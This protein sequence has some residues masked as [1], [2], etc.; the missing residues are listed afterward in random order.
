V[1]L[2]RLEKDG[3]TIMISGKEHDICDVRHSFRK[4]AFL[5]TSLSFC[6]LF[7]LFT[8]NRIC[9]SFTFSK[10]L[11]IKKEPFVVCFYPCFASL[12]AFYTSCRIKLLTMQE[13]GFVL[14]GDLVTDDNNSSK[15]VSFSHLGA[16]NRNHALT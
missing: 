4:A 8:Q 9:W 15:L 3:V 10:L 7:L 2:T 11:L 12:R 6:T 13:N 16:F 14:I 5:L 1:D